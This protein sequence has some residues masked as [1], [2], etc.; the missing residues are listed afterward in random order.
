MIRGT[1]FDLSAVPYAGTEAIEG[2]H[3]RASGSPVLS[4]QTPAEPALA[5]V[6]G[7]LAAGIKRIL[8][9]TGTYQAGDEWR[10]TR[11]APRS[12]LTSTGPKTGSSARQKGGIAPGRT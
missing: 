9:S 10:F 8:A 4:S 7:A 6:D 1:L 11:G 12:W 3:N 2:A 5:D